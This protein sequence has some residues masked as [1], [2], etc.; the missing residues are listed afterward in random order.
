MLDIVIK[1]GRII[2][3]T[4]NSWYFG[5]IGIMGGKIV[6][7]AANIEEPA[8]QTLDARGLVVTPGFV[9]IHS[10]SDIPIVVDLRAQS[11]VQQGVTT[12]LTGQCGHSA[13]PAIGGGAQRERDRKSVV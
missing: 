12:E 7:I 1:N 11:K 5:E 9:D 8:L 2:D 10:H 4:G 13:A 6:K 3:G